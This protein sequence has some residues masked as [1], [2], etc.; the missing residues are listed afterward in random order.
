MIQWYFVLAAMFCSVSAVVAAPLKD[1]KLQKYFEGEVARI[2]A[3]SFAGIDSAEDWK[4]ARPKLHRELREML[5]LDPMPAKTD[6]RAMVTGKVERE[7]IVVEK[8]H[9]QSSPG[10]YVTGNFYRPAKVE[11]RLSAVLYLCEIGRASCRE[12]V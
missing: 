1:A 11:G 4:K 12:R 5:G 8:L 6:L 9:F 2:E 7:G 3:H 10:L